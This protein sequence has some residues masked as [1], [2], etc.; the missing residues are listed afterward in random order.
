MISVLENIYIFGGLGEN[1]SKNSMW[2]YNLGLATYTEDAGETVFNVPP[3][4]S[5]HK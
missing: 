4:T 1:E 2:R 5:Y 3:A